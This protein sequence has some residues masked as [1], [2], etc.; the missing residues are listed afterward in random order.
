MALTTEQ[1]ATLDMQLAVLNQ[2]HTNQLAFEAIRHANQLVIT[3]KQKEV[4]AVRVAQSVL[5][6]NA[7][8]KPASE[9]EITP[10]DITA[11]ANTLLA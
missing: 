10:A 2:Q 5:I 3:N 11:F 6:E 8:S 4:D 1:Q 7:R 9:R